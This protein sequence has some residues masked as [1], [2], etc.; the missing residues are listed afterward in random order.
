MS[1]LW[2]EDEAR[3]CAQ[4]SS[5][6]RAPL[7]FPVASF[8]APAGGGTVGLPQNQQRPA[9][10]TQR[11]PVASRSRVAY[12]PPNFWQQL[13]AMSHKV[14]IKKWRRTSALCAEAAVSLLLPAIVIAIVSPLVNDIR[15]P[16]MC[17]GSLACT[18]TEPLPTNAS[19]FPNGPFV[20]DGRE[21]QSTLLFSPNSAAHYEVMEDV[22]RLLRMPTLCLEGHWNEDTLK[23]F[24]VNKTDGAANQYRAAVYLPEVIGPS[25][26]EQAYRVALPQTT[27]SAVG[28][29]PSC[30][31]APSFVDG[32]DAH[33]RDFA[34]AA[35]GDKV[36]SPH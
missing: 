32:I 15:S 17:T 29:C 9:R 34:Q 30:I 18:A 2:N 26:L 4:A 16:P 12:A 10:S 11:V 27:G 8:T 33:Q 25:N 3:R 21:T 23:A 36:C 28:W 24:Y 7:A 22:R 19:L 5:E 13:L 31:P 14:L 35:G 20:C 1:I 6:S